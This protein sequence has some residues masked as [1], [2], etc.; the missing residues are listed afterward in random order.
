MVPE[1][2]HRTNL[3]ILWEEYETLRRLAFKE[4]K[5]IS[6][7]LREAI[8]EYVER[9][10]TKQGGRMGVSADL[11]KFRMLRVLFE[12]EAGKGSFSW[13]C[14]EREKVK[15]LLRRGWIKQVP[16]ELFSRTGKGM[17]ELEDIRKRPLEWFLENAEEVKEHLKRGWIQQAAPHFVDLTAA[18]KSE[19]EKWRKEG[20]RWGRVG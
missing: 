3:F 8:L 10:Q 20:W 7:L 19:L 13:L 12:I 1:K 6:E 16:R 11:E 18:G 17:G 14:E 9:R 2:W 15:K 4:R 5:T